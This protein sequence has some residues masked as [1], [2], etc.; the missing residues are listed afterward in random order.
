M[1]VDDA[2]G[3]LMS[4]LNSREIVDQFNVVIVSDHGMMAAKE[5]KRIYLHDYIP[6]LD[7]LT[8]WTDLGPV[9]GLI[10]KKNSMF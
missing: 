3:Q 5:S 9:A 1:Q 8:S 6:N 10:P 7:A 2:V 4:E